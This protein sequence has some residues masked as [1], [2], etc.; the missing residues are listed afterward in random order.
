MDS[1]E[2]GGRQ[3]PI[4]N[5]YPRDFGDQTLLTQTASSAADG[6][7]RAGADAAGLAWVLS[8]KNIQADSIPETHL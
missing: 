1:I 5:W 7:A 6:A 4:G 8:C 3:W 2:K